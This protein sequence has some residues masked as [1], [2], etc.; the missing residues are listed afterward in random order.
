MKIE[1]F[2]VVRI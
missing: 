2:A 1:I